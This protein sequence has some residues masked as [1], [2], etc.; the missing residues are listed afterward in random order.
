MRLAG[1]LNRTGR[2][3]FIYVL[4]LLC[5]NI[6]SQLEFRGESRYPV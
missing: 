3:S 4:V 5:Y 2:D 6:L 1:H